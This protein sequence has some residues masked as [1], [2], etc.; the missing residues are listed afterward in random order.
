[1]NIQFKMNSGHLGQNCNLV[2]LQIV[3]NIHY[4]TVKMF[5]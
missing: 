1:M 3:L 4:M 2:W 5:S